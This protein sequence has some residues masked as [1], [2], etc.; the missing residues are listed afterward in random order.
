MSPRKWP[1]RIEDILDAVDEIESFVR[2]LAYE[3]FARDTKCI[4]AVTA[5]L[6]IIGEA[7]KHIPEDVMA[8]HPEIPWHS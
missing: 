1:R 8:A 6:A 4:K 7:A 5:D 3:E 2:G